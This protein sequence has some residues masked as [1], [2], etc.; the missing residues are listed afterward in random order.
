M[1][2][3]WLPILVL[4]LVTKIKLRRHEGRTKDFIKGGRFFIVLVYSVIFI[5]YGYSGH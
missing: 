2:L 1:C 3:P 5:V 4:N